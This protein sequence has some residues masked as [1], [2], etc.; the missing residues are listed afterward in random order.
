VYACQSCRAHVVIAQRL[1]EPIEKGLPAPGF[2]ARV[3]VSKYAD[4]LPLCRQEGIFKRFGVELS[5]S[6]MCSWMAVVAGLLN[7]IVKA[8]LRRVLL[9]RVVQTDDTTVP[10]QDLDG[11]GIKTGRLWVH[12][13]DWGN[14]FIV[15][16]YT[17]DRSSDGPG[18]IFQGF[19]GYLQAAAYSDCDAF[20]WWK[21]RRGRLL[22][23]RPAEVP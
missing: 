5:R 18:R 13:G 12:F 17:P 19:E 3:A 11:P 15:H 8:R 7:P 14:R 9:S 23:A 10:V 2:L 21:D 16:D 6:T 20:R 4:H 22:D 1:P